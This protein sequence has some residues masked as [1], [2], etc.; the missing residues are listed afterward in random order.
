MVEYESDYL[1][2]SNLGSYTDTDESDED[3]AQRVKS[4]NRNYNPKGHFTDFVLRLRFEDLKMF[5]IAL[6]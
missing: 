6:F 5:K 2:S 1:D 3:D 4:S